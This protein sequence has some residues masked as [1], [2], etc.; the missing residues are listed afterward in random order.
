MGNERKNSKRETEALVSLQVYSYIKWC[1][2][3]NRKVTY[4]HNS[5]SSSNIVELETCLYVNDSCHELPD[6]LNTT[7]S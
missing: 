6:Q 1:M 7:N 2:T 3:T 4:T 5:C